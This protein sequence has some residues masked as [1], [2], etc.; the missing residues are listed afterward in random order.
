MRARFRN[1]TGHQPWS[2]L[3]GISVWVEATRRFLAGRMRCAGPLGARRLRPGLYTANGVPVTPAG[4]SWGAP[5]ALQK[6]MCF[7]VRACD[8]TGAV[9]SKTQ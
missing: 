3:E 9:I 1:E 5:S 2:F 7:S 4:A 8:V 6:K